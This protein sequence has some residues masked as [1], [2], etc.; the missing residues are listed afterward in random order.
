MSNE[1]PHKV[2]KSRSQRIWRLISSTLNPRVWA[3]GIKVLNYYSHTHVT[4][5]QKATLGKNVRMSPMAS[6]ANA[7]NLYIKD[8]ARIGANV[9]LWAGPGR[10]KIVIGEDTMIAPNVMVT[11]ANYRFNDGSPITSQTM[12]EGDIT[13]GDDVWIGHGV[14]I[15]P[16]A[17]IGDGAVIGAGAVVRGEVPANAV[18]TGEPA[19]VVGA[20]F[21]QSAENTPDVASGPANDRITALVLQEFSSLQASDLELKLD[22]TGIDSFD[23]ISLRT[24]IENQ[25]G[26]AIPDRE[27]ASLQ[28]LA[29]IAKLPTLA[30]SAQT[31]TAPLAQTP[32][33]TAS[34]PSTPAPVQITPGQAARHYTIDMPQMAL[35]G[36]SEAWLFKELGDIHW[37]MITDFLQSPSSAIADDEGDR[38][39][40]T[41]TRLYLEATPKL[42]DFKENDT[43]ALSSSLQRYGGSFFFGTHELSAQDVGC[44]AQTMSTFAKYG[45]RGKN[46]SLI[47]GTPTLPD[48]DSV[49][50]MEAFPAFGTEYRVRRGEDPAEAIFECEYE[51]LPSH[52]INGVGLL[53]FAAYPTIFDLC[54]EKFE[55]KGFLIEYSTVSKDLY[56][57]A[58]S[59][60][61]ETLIFRV[62]TRDEENDTLRHTASL[63]RKSDGKRMGEVISIKRR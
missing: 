18:L 21:I 50:S 35:S 55:G 46:T 26:T 54:L 40:A 52:D 62:H 2:D 4:E 47:K 25:T 13:I 22:E 38:L 6:F 61:T 16:G 7:Q 37:Q 15:L 23:L 57:Y 11:A 8:R 42:R 59:E 14:T 49:P 53:Y 56:Y 24:V 19:K 20:R 29:D 58:N 17:K 28:T 30:G 9:S 48:P 63:S 51:I 44:R 3:H 10:G 33:V 12:D 36:L 27:W 5:L 39:Y 34:A 45:E 43:L 1:K 41:F 31:R 32:S 60:P